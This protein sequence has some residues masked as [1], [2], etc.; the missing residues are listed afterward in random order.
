MSERYSRFDI[1]SLCSCTS[2][3][4]F[5]S[6]AANGFFAGV[7]PCCARN[8]APPPHTIIAIITIATN[9]LT[10]RAL[11]VSESSAQSGPYLKTSDSTLDAPPLILVSKLFSHPQSVLEE[12][13]WKKC[14]GRRSSPSRRQQNETRPHRHSRSRQNHPRL[15]NLLTPE[16]IRLQRRTRHRSRAPIPI[17]CQ[18]RHH[19]RRPALDSPRPNRRRTRRRPPRTSRHLR[20]RRPRQ[21]LLPRQ[22][23]R[24][25]AAPRA[26]ARLVDELLLVS[27]RRPA[28]RIF[29]IP[30]DGFRS[31][32]RAFQQR[33]HDLLNELLVT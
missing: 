3:R 4:I 15:R 17:P 7:T 8:T 19:S 16:K 23:I 25:P 11:I 5:S 26:L 24:P 28:R 14:A 31:E 18:R 10:R 9:P 12:L 13:C 6:A 29:E 32:D 21:L 2:A 33:I 27:R 22:Q 30:S 20:S 1:I